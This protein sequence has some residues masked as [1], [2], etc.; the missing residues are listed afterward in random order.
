M[1]SIIPKIVHLLA[2][3]KS[4]VSLLIM[5]ILLG[6]G[7]RLAERFL[8][9]YLMALGGGTLAVGLL[10]GFNNLLGA[11]Y[12][13][14][15]GWLSDKL[16]YKR[17]L[18]VFNIIAMLGYL[19]VILLPYWQFAII[20]TMLFLS[21]TSISL[22][23]SMELISDVLPKNKATMGVSMHSLV[24]RFPMAL[25]P[26]AGGLLIGIY[27]I[28]SGIKA[29]FIISFFLALL[30]LVFQQILIKEPEK[31]IHERISISGLFGKFNPELRQLLLSDILVR[32]CEQIPYAFVVIWC[33]KI[34][35]LSEF[36]FGI[37]T[38]VEMAVA[39]LCYIPVAYFADKTSKK[40]FVVVT[41]IFFAL[42]PLL[43]LF[44]HSF[45]MMLLAFSLRGLKEFGEPTRKALI[46]E[47]A[48]EGNK[49]SAFGLYYL[50]RDIFVSIAAF[51]GAL[52]WDPTILSRVF[53]FA[54]WNAA[55]RFAEIFC[56]PEANLLIA[57]A[58]GF[59]GA[60]YLLKSKSHS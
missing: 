7:E 43:L 37:L 9:L 11:L 26:L 52:F 28:E 29:A 59:A 27:G 15:G 53:D 4:I 35:G 56:R 17:A 45:W 20:G 57:S 39:V 23:A 40:P 36:D 49:A 13:Y 10:G 58:C 25:G 55:S 41:F 54:G 34:N 38:A 6:L 5:V 1:N 24:R 21:W 19:M 33:V 46:M 3:K 2:L 60:L 18:A 50:I 42:F 47:L 48:P 44:S 30:S 31:K 16:G 8:P 14:P 12:S 51:A 32:F 22:P